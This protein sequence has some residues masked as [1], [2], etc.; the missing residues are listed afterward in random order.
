MDLY[1]GDGNEDNRNVHDIAHAE[2]SGVV[3]HSKRVLFMPVFGFLS[4]D[5][6]LPLRYAPIQIELE[7]VNNGVD[8]VQVNTKGGRTYTANWD[9]S[10]VQCKCDLFTLDNALGN[11][12][13]S[14]LLYGKSLPISFSTWN[15]S[16]Q[17]TG[18][19]SNSPAHINRS[20]IRLISF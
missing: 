10:D 6:L 5:I 17:A 18:N 3:H 19:N 11:E 13:A 8:A 2:D 15:H 9:M 20:L 1:P 7:L 4:Q 14:H 12:Y 16:R